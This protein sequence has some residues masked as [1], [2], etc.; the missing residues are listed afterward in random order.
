MLEGT[1]GQTGS[2][3]FTISLFLFYYISDAAA[4]AFVVG[5][6]FMIQLFFESSTSSNGKR[7]DSETSAAIYIALGSSSNLISFKLSSP[8]AVCVCVCF[9]Q[10]K[11]LIE[12]VNDAKHHFKVDEG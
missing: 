5:I 8:S 2:A 10:H 1:N 9:K 12:K 7:M 4:A 11:Q 6:Q 3:M